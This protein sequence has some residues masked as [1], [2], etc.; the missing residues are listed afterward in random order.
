MRSDLEKYLQCEATEGNFYN[1]CIP[2]VLLPA[3]LL[4]LMLISSLVRFWRLW[5]GTTR[6]PGTSGNNESTPLLG[7]APAE[8]EARPVAISPLLISNGAVIVILLLELMVIIA[9][10]LFD[11]VWS[12]TIYTLYLL[13]GLIAWCACAVILVIEFYAIGSVNKAWVAYWYG[14]LAL[15]IEFL[16]F[17][18]WAMAVRKGNPKS[19]RKVTR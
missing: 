5:R 15:P 9:R 2:N 13:V 6:S 14:I 1:T 17:I 16:M 18:R 4:N 10:A 8:P 11:S 12:S 7:F 3:A 19:N